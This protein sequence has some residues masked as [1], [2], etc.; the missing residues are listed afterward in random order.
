LLAVASHRDKG[1]TSEFIVKEIKIALE[2]GA[3]AFVIR[4]ASVAPSWPTELVREIVVDDLSTI[5]DQDLDD[6]M[7]NLVEVPKPP[8]PAQCF[9]GHPIEQKWQDLWDHAHRTVQAATGLQCIDGDSVNDVDN[10]PQRITEYIR[11]ATYCLFDISPKENGDQA[12]NTYI[13]AGIRIGAN[14]PF[15]IICRGPRRDPPFMFKTRQVEYYSDEADMIARIRL[16][17]A[18]YQRILE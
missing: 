17:C 12:T 2:V 13:E 11:N 16:L 8:R 18:P 3:P 14:K 9:F 7:S 1:A 15:G 10:V 5:T 6:W 4:E